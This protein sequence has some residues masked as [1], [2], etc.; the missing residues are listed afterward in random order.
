MNSIF[1]KQLKIGAAI[2]GGLLVVF[3]G[4]ALTVNSCYEKRDIATW[5]ADV[6]IKGAKPWGSTAFKIDVT[7]LEKVD[8]AWATNFTNAAIEINEELNALFGLSPRLCGEGISPCTS[9]SVFDLAEVDVVAGHK[10]LYDAKYGDRAFCQ[11]QKLTPDQVTQNDTYARN[12]PIGKDYNARV[13][14]FVIHV[15]HKKYEK[16][17]TYWR[18]KLRE[19]LLKFGKKNIAKHEL[20]HLFFYRH[21]EVEGGIIDND[22]GS[23]LL[24][25]GAIKIFKLKILPGYIA[26][27]HLNK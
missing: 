21:V 12:I 20:Y 2:F 25:P 24:G 18:T 9:H 6:A 4:I 7:N 5:H 23:D 26:K 3:L 8:R 19:K 13:T 27:G 11:Y 17:M 15:C 14:K 16:S 22:A 1:T 10:L